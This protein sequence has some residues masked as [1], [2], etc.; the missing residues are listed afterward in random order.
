MM[1]CLCSRLTAPGAKH[2]RD[3]L[4]GIPGLPRDHNRIW[5]TMRFEDKVREQYDQVAGTYDVRW[6]AYVDATLYALKHYLALD[7]TEAVLDVGC[8]TGTF[9]KMLVTDH[10]LL[11]VEGVDLSENM[12]AVAGRKLAMHPNATLVQGL[13][14]ALPQEHGAFDVVVSSSAFH[15]FEKPVAALQE[16]RRVLKPGGKLVIMDWRRDFWIW[17]VCHPFLRAFDP[18][19]KG[20]YTPAEFSAMMR[21]AGFRVV[22]ERSVRLRFW[23]GMML[24]KGEA[25]EN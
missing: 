12:L 11:R 19:Y 17:Q 15:Y 1:I 14:H 18:A 5:F 20:C 2:W 16:A 13:A 24:V 9:M 4:A 10:P 23:W 25:A 6:R 22:D 7:G 3:R 21:Q 8:G